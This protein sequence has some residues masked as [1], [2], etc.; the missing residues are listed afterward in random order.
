MFYTINKNKK[1]KGGGGKAIYAV[2]SLYGISRYYCYMKKHYS[3]KKVTN[4]RKYENL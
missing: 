1:N 3:N 4:T 2:A